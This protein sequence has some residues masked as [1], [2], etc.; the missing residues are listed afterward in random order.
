[1]NLVLR[2]SDFVLAIPSDHSIVYGKISD[3]GTGPKMVRSVKFSTQNL[4]LHLI[5]SKDDVI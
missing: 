5:N 2:I 1:M 3:E 4:S